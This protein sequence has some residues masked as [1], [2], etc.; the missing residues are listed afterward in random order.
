MPCALLVSEDSFKLLVY[1]MYY[2]PSSSNESAE[3]YQ[4]HRIFSQSSHQCYLSIM[5][6]LSVQLLD[7]NYSVYC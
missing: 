4:S 2:Q 6:Q 1:C 5:S 7:T 3:N